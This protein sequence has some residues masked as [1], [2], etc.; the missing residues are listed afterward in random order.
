MGFIN[1][2]NLS[3]SLA[4]NFGD[5]GFMKYPKIKKDI[6]LDDIK[7]ALELSE[8]EKEELKNIILKETNLKNIVDK[9]EKNI[10]VYMSIRKNMKYLLL[11]IIE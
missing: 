8:N 9:I 7:K 4:S 1:K 11:C 3:K 10:L 6:L 5:I 2:E